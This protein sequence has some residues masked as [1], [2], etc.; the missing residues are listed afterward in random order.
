MKRQVRFVKTRRVAGIGWTGGVAALL[1]GLSAAPR[2]AADEAFSLTRAV[3]DDVFIVAASRFSPERD[4]LR[5]YWSEVWDEFVKTGI[6]KDVHELVRS[7]LDEEQA[8]E[9]DRVMERFTKLIEG[10][11]WKEI[12]S[13]QFVFAERFPHPLPTIDGMPIGMPDILLAVRSADLDASRNFAGLKAILDAIVEEVNKAAGTELAL[14][15]RTQDGIQLTSLNLTAGEPKAPRIIISIGRGNDTVFMCLGQEIASDVAALLAGKGP[16][17]S[18]A[19]NPRFKT[20]FEKLPA[21]ESEIT[22]FD[23]GNLLTSMKALFGGMLDKAAA[24]NANPGGEGDQW[25]ATARTILDRLLESAAILDHTASVSYT[26]GYSIHMDTVAVL[27]KDARANPLYP[28]VAAHHPVADFARFLPKET[29]S[30]S[31]SGGVELDALYKY[32]ED[33]LKQ[34]GEPGQQLLEQWAAFQKEN[35]FDIHRDVIDWIDGESVTGSFKLD[36]RDAWIFM[37]KVN[38]EETAR[39]K[40]AW[41][42]EFLSARLAELAAEAPMLAMLTIRTEPAL[43]EKLEGFHD[44]A[45]GFMPLPAACGV[46]DGW[47]MLGS[48][49]DAVLRCLDTAAG[50]HPNV[51]ENQRLMSEAL[52]PD[53]PADAFSYTDHRGTAQQI[54]EVL[55]G[56]SMAG[57]MIAMMIPEP[58][59][60]RAVMKVFGIIAKLAPVVARID[61][62]KS[63]STHTTFDGKAWHT[64]AVTHYFSPEE[65]KAAQTATP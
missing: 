48:S 11:D 22:F 6:C 14:E 8:A 63:S 56:V 13:G 33:T 53:G 47:L 59:G 55:G 42:L 39:E 23:M 38:N 18:I 35:D 62:Y 34:T 2:A 61:F 9:M 58:E 41:S 46:R 12:D 24:E 7:A 50:K 10:V 44:V 43:D 26:D 36:G 49:E 4:F 52:V 3:P 29:V 5:G 28:V 60:Q 30:F 25:A 20:A 57:G 19:D 21:A 32:A 51:R 65:R 17:K 54:A 37:L 1:L 16:A 31:V 64:K 40:L 45:M 15:D 27:S